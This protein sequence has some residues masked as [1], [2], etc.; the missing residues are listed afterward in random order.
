MELLTFVFAIAL[1]IGLGMA[2]WF[3]TKSGQK[4]IDE[5]KIIEK[6][7]LKIWLFAELSVT[8]PPKFRY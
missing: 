1:A 8:L 2:I 3:N 7:A 4:W 6:I 5:L